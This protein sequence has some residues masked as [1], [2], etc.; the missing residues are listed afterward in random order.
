MGHLKS[1]LAFII[2]LGLYAG[3][4]PVWLPCTAIYCIFLSQGV[5]HV[6]EKRKLFKILVK[7]EK[8]SL[9]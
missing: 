1:V 6:W 3:V 5:D 4:R 9:N 2:V 7:K 8:G